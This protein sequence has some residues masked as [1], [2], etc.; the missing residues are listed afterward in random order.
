MCTE[1]YLCKKDLEKNK[2]KTIDLFYLR[3]KFTSNS[4]LT[5]MWKRRLCILPSMPLRAISISN[6]LIP[7]G[8]IHDI[9]LSAFDRD[10]DSLLDVSQIHL[11]F[12]KEEI[13]LGNKLIKEIGVLNG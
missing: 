7:G 3:S 13:N 9:G 11:S 12:T 4:Y 10:I 1:L 8:K 6:K 2:I 5:L